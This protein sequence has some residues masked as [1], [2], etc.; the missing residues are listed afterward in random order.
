MTISTP[1]S[2]EI[3]EAFVAALGR[4]HDTDVA[5]LAQELTRIL[6][7]AR[8]A[9]PELAPDDAA[10][11]GHVAA[12]L[13]ADEPVGEALDRLRPADLYLAWGCARGDRAAIV[14]FE[15]E[16]GDQ[17]RLALTK[18]DAPAQVKEDA[19]QILRER[20]W[21]AHGSRPPRV[22]DYAGRGQLRRWVQAAAVRTCIDLVRQH[23][24]EIALDDRHAAA[25]PAAD[26][27][28]ELAHL[29]RLY[30][31]VFH[32][33]FEAAIA[34]LDERQQTMLRHHLVD[35]LTI[36]DIG[37]LYGVHRTT[38]YRWIDRARDRL[39]TGTRQEMVARLAVE[40]REVDSILRVIR[41]EV[42]LSVKRYLAAP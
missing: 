7:E 19:V 14:A 23:R 8:S 39:V 11:A 37:A 28:P 34:R 42:H 27:D 9:W 15:R 33:S 22:A 18:V 24:R 13:P 17:I 30:G 26:A 10:F 5:I 40:P 29:R 16:L 6:R 20:L 2:A 25:L 1:V 4:P 31:P 35:G 3:L 36:D 21:V 41:S 32:E 38:A 12:R